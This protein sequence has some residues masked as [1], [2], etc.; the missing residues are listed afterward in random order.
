LPKAHI[1]EDKF[2]SNSRLLNVLIR[3]LKTGN[4]QAPAIKSM[5]PLVAGALIY[6]TN[7]R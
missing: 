5:K 1:R 2:I 6:G 3:I 7:K 4:S